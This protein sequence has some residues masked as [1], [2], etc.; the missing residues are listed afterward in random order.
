MRLLLNL[1][2]CHIKVVPPD[3]IMGRQEEVGL[4]SAL[5][6]QQAETLPREGQAW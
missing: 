6:K 2:A 4:R 5:L 3:S 1:K